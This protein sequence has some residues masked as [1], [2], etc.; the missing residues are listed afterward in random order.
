M[1][2]LS[3]FA[4]LVA[5]I[6]ALGAGIQFPSGAPSKSPDGRW[7]LICKGPANGEAD[8]PRLLLLNRVQGRSVELRRIDR[9]CDTMWSPDSARIALTDRWASDS[10]DI[11]IYAV[12]DR[13]S[14]KSVR[15][16]FPTN[17]IPAAELASHC[18]FEACEWLD[19]RRLRFKVSGHTDEFPVHSFDH[20][21]ILTVTSGRFEKATKKKPNQKVRPTGASRSAVET[22]R[23]SSPAGFRR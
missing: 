19:R 4:L 21:Y 6:P 18:Y 2:P 14:S 12:A 7:N 5:A 11:F 1:N 3:S 10:S 23:T 8:W 13:V 9:Y 15:E 20:E 22:N 17:A 16:L